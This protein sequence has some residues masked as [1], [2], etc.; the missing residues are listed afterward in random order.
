MKY[1]LAVSILLLSLFAILCEDA[2]SQW[3][4]DISNEL[5][6]PDILDVESSLS[7]LYVL[8][9]SEGLVVFRTYEDSLQW[10]YASR[11]MQRRGNQLHADIR[12]AYLFGNGRRLTVIEPTSVL[13]VYSS[14]VLPETPVSVRRFGNNLYVVLQNGKLVTVSLVTPQSVDTEPVAA[15]PDRLKNRT[16][17][18]LATDENRVLYVLSDNSIIDIYRYSSSEEE[19]IHDDEVELSDSVNKIFF[20]GSELIG[21]NNSGDIFLIDSNGNTRHQNNVESQVTKLGF[22]NNEIVVRNENNKLWIGEPGG[23]ITKWK[24]NERAGNHFTINKNRLFVSESNSLFPVIR[25]A[26]TDR[27]A[28]TGREADR[29]AIK[30]IETVTIPFP[31]PLLLSLE[32]EGYAGDVSNI[33]FSVES[34]INNIRVR[35][36]SLFWQPGASDTGRQQIEVTA[37]TPAGQNAQMQFIVDV[38]PF[39]SPP[40][41]TPTRPHTIPAD[42]AFEQQISAFDPDGTHPD[43]IRYLGVD[44]PSGASL[45]EQTGVFRWTPTI[46]QVGTHT[47]RVIAT[48]QFGAAASQEFELQVAEVGDAEEPQIQNVIDSQ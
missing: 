42:E 33:T 15:D 18:D 36:N 22:W 1:T 48:D 8:S 39:N 13:G 23:E 21:S 9:E 43:L 12:F 45:N 14:T 3:N 19:L 35:G 16:V 38:R 5:E 34:S 28:A 26:D 37:I 4:H 7:H 17:N 11:G 24:E 44:L 10:L 6:I 31:K 47:F 41:F 27:R 32:I 25:T 40:R 46:R 20:T 2:F 30:Q 29:F